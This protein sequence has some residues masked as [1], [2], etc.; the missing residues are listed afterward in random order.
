METAYNAVLETVSLYLCPI[1]YLIG[2][3]VFGVASYIELVYA[4]VPLAPMAA[5]S[6]SYSLGMAYFEASYDRLSIT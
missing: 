1:L 5:I 4:L 6:L 2:R 3:N